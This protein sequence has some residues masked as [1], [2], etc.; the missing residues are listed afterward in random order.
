MTF[1]ED[2]AA[3]S[4]TAEA[5]GLAISGEAYNPS[6]SWTEERERLIAFL[7]REYAFSSDGVAAYLQRN[8]DVAWMLIGAKRALQSEFGGSVAIQ[9]AVVTDPDSEEPTQELFAYV[10]SP[11]RLDD[12][13]DALDRFDQHWYLDKVDQ[14]GGRL[15]FDLSFA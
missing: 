2:D 14:I 1:V 3:V 7:Q 15:G 6:S 12:A 4:A 11:L 13:L 10:R 8:S 9:L 5:L